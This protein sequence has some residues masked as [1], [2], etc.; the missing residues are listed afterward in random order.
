MLDD[1]SN[2]AAAVKAIA[3]RHDWT[4]RETEMK[5]VFFIFLGLYAFAVFIWLVGTFGLFGQERDPLSA[6]FLLPLGLP[7]NFLGD[8]MGATGA[9]LGVGAPAI[10]AAI[11]FWIW[12]R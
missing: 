8:R 10:N 9:A 5:W 1:T 2:A 12:R 6:V 3:Q 7:W 4:K 11:L